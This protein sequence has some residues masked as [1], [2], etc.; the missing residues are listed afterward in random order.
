MGVLHQ[1][2]SFSGALSLQGPLDL[3]Q[4]RHPKACPRRINSHTPESTGMST[5]VLEEDFAL[6][7]LHTMGIQLQL[8]LQVKHQVLRDVYVATKPASTVKKT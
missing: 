8:L 2:I 6:A 7:N 1:I 3:H 4:C 5:T